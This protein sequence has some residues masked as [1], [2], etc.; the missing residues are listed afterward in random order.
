MLTLAVFIAFCTGAAV[1]CLCWM[2]YWKGYER[3]WDERG[4]R[5]SH[6]SILHVKPFDQDH[7]P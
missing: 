4:F 7:A 6:K 5:L 2:S 1:A 3:G